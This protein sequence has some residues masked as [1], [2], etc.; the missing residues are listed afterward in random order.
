MKHL[1]KKLSAC[2]AEV[3]GYTSIGGNI[4]NLTRKGSSVKSFLNGYEVYNVSDTD[5]RYKESSIV[6]ASVIDH[7]FKN[8]EEKK[9]RLYRSEWK[10]TK[11]SSTNLLEDIIPNLNE[12]VGDSIVVVKNKPREERDIRLKGAPGFSVENGVPL[13]S[14]INNLSV[15]KKKMS[16]IARDLEEALDTASTF[17]R[18]KLKGSM[19]GAKEMQKVLDNLYSEFISNYWNKA[20]VNI[21]LIERSID[22]LICKLNMNGCVEEKKIIVSILIP[23]VTESYA[24]IKEVVIKMVTLLAPLIVIDKTFTEKTSYPARFFIPDEVIDQTQ[25]RFNCLIDFLC[26]APIIE[27]KVLDPLDFV[28]VNMLNEIKG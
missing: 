13:K 18:R 5:P 11:E 8:S 12:N 14:L 9:I 3:I 19:W 26:L 25:D 2:N 24:H 22:K 21:E 1:F 16:G 20:D 23:D 17:T 4:F 27:S 28:R 7:M 10:D 15:L 6:L